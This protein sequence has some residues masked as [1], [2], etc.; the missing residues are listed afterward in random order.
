MAE[1]TILRQYRMQLIMQLPRGG[2]TVY[3]PEGKYKINETIRI[4]A[5]GSGSVTLAGDP[6]RMRK[7]ILQSGPVVGGDLLVVERPD[8]HISYLT[9]KNNASEGSVLE[10]GL[11]KKRHNGVQLLQG[12]PK[13]QDTAVVVSGSENLYRKLLFRAGDN[14][15]LYNNFRK[16]AGR[17][18]KANTLADSYFGG[19]LPKSVL[20]DSEESEACPQEIYILRNVFL[21]PQQA[22]SMLNP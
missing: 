6:N 5:E 16:K 7:T 4:S 9:I 15:W 20:I 14:K 3:F 8:V 22:R 13:N 2:G 21:F 11:S 19:D 10:P 18:M 17:E 1:L 12:N